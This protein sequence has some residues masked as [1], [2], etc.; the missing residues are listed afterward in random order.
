MTFTEKLQS[1]VKQS[2]STLC[3]GLDPN[4]L[5]LPTAVKKQFDSIDQQVAFFCK[6]VIDY[7]QEFACAYKPNLAFFEAL[8]PAGLEVFHQVIE[9][10]P[11]NKIVIADA[12]RGDISTT[13]EH[14]KI[15]FFDGFDVDAITLNPLMGFETLDAFSHDDSKAIYALT[16]TSNPGSADFLKKPFEGFDMMG[17]YIASQ[18]ALKSESTLTHLGMVI[19]ATQT[20]TLTSVISNHPAASL[21]IPGIGAQGGSIDDL[22]RALE[23]HSGIPVINSSRGIIY[24]GSD[25]ENWIEHVA[26]S[27]SETKQRLSPITERYV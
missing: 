9:H 2:S 24:A 4:L 10:I 14:Y 27:A 23:H 16:L 15:S 20:D 25:Q 13:A 1:A 18:L 26:R 8:G 19:G 12:K 22:V 11:D 21:L 7:T 5:L 3:V 6:L 17:Q